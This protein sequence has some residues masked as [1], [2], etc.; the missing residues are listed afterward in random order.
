M[1]NELGTK[2]QQLARENHINYFLLMLNCL[3]APYIS[4]QCSRLMALYF[5]CSGLDIL[6]AVDK[7]KDKKVLVDWI[8]A[9]QCEEGGFIGGGFAPRKKEEHAENYRQGHVTMTYTALLTLAILG[10]DL[11]RVDRQQT[12]KWLRSLQNEDGSFQAVQAG[13]ETDVRFV[14]SAAAICFMLQDYTGVDIPKARD[15]LLSV[16]SHDGG[17]GML[18]GQESHAG[19]EAASK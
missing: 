13:S 16:Q 4:L 6:C 9:Q 1:S 7:I 18:P 2:P 5:C 12:S 8:Y 10:D 15:F 17:I 19:K 3:P 14:F 11:S